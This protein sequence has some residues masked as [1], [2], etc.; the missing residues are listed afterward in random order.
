MKAG[1]PTRH[2]RAKWVTWRD[3]A[4]SET[5]F[6]ELNRSGKVEM[7]GGRPVPH[8][9]VPGDDHSAPLLKPR[10]MEAELTPK[11]QVDRQ[12]PGSDGT[13]PVEFNF[14][15]VHFKERGPWNGFTYDDFG[16]GP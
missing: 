6:C 8:H 9:K 5:I 10:V 1:R 13:S 15:G 16:L 3:A 2:I 14:T 7:N 4:S 11:T 12:A